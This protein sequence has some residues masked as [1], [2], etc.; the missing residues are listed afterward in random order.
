MALSLKQLRC[1][2]A[3]AETGNFRRA[4]ALCGMTQPSLS[5]QIKNLEGELGGRLVERGRSGVTPTPFGREVVARAS[6]VLQE[7]DGILD[8]ARSS[9]G[10]LTGTIRL[11]ATPT[12]GPYL[13]PYAVAELHSRY[14]SLRLYV[15]ESPPS[16]LEFEL[17]KGVHDV[18]LTQTPTGLVDAHEELLFREP[19]YLAMAPD[20][21]LARK[22]AIE[23]RDLAGEDVLALTR[24]YRLHDQVA[25]LCEAYG[26]RLVRDYDGTSLDALRQ[27]VGMGMGVAFLPA[28][29]VRSEI[30][31]EREVAVKPIAGRSVTRSLGLVWRATSGAEAAFRA[32]A[33]VLRVAG[34][35]RLKA[36]TDGA[37]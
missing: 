1:L 13:L 30:R 27:M 11:G 28:L 16:D 34:E 22:A 7:A 18:V 35:H 21:P 8:F 23:P 14:P 6:K 29:Y 20:H 10:L 5:A 25:G 24:G 31:G 9:G 2:T 32:L 12:L 4:A 37:R 26:A 17:E 33:D 19:L 15:R 3:L 36:A